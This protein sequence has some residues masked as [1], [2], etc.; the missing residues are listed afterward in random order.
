[1]KNNLPTNRQWRAVY[2][3]LGLEIGLD[4]GDLD[5]G[6]LVARGRQKVEAV[7]VRVRGRV[8]LEG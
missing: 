1:M 6:K 7:R 3:K 4:L 8:T 5:L 2:E